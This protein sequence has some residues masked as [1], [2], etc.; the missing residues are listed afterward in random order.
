M[1]ISC[2]LPLSF[3]IAIHYH[4]KWFIITFQSAMIEIACKSICTKH[5]LVNLCITM[6]RVNQV[7]IFFIT[8]I[9]YKI[10]TRRKREKCCMYPEPFS[11]IWR[12][13]EKN[14]IFFGHVI[15]SIGFPSE[16]Y[17]FIIMFTKVYTRAHA[18][19]FAVLLACAPSIFAIVKQYFSFYVWN[20]FHHSVINKCGIWRI[21]YSIQDKWALVWQNANRFIHI[22]WLKEI[23]RTK[24]V[25]LVDGSTKKQDIK[26]Y[27][28]YWYT[29]II[30]GRVQI[31]KQTQGNNINKW[32]TMAWGVYI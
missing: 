11:H 10:E 13:R 4:N 32:G 25:Y 14:R 21:C 7:T 15:F 24:Y 1:F 29:I 12:A 22:L 3:P 8:L 16:T 9:R 18:R 6:L 20:A 28:S 26:L 19:M 31:L 30:I 17:L 2:C 23:C 5:F 27:E